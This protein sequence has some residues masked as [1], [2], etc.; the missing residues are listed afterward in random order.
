MVEEPVTPITHSLDPYT[1]DSRAAVAYEVAIEAING[2][3][4]QY[5]A[6]IAREERRPEQERD[7]TAIAEW[8][9]LQRECQQERQRLDPDNAEDVARVRQEYAAL[10]RDLRERRA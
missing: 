3:V 6:L 7:Q 8:Q 5:T 2:V 4:G 1:W 9:R 10:E